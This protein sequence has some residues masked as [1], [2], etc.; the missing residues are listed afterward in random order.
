MSLVVVRCPACLG[1]SR[2]ATEALGL[3]V[4]CPRCEVPFIAAEEVVPVV[5][6]VARGRVSGGGRSALAP[7]VEP[8]RRRQRRDEE[9]QPEPQDESPATSRIP[10][11][12]HDPHLPPVAGLPVSVLVGLALLPLAIPVFWWAAPFVTGQP[13]AL[14]LAVP[15]SLAFAA[16]TLCLGVVYTIDWTAATRIKGVLMLVGLAYLAAAGLYFLKR[17][18]VERVQRV[19]GQRIAWRPVELDGTVL[20]MPGQAEEALDQPLPTVRMASGWKAV[21]E[22]AINDEYHYLALS[23]RLPGPGQP[24][25]D[26]FEAVGAHLAKSGKV[27]AHTDVPLDQR[28]YRCHQW[29]LQ[30]GDNTARVVRVYVIENRVYYLHVEG[31]NID[32]SDA[33]LVEPFFRYFEFDKPV[34]KP[35][36]KAKR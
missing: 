36:G 32:P 6:P 31:R 2:V 20:R 15:L 35:K 3:T 14:S 7:P 27:H 22:S 30:T 28:E 34:G 17:E 10:D 25:A 29:T 12:E 18:L 33:E 21:Y 19:G 13:A 9:P 23:G 8:P 4:G 26:W 24:D 5:M 16:T 1:E 11:P